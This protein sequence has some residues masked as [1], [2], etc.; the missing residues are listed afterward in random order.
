MNTRIVVA[1]V[2]SVACIA[3]SPLAFGQSQPP[4]AVDMKADAVRLTATGTITAI[5]PATRMVTVKGQ[6]DRTVVFTAGPSVRNFDNMK[7]GDKVAVDYE[8][9]VA[10]ALRKGATGRE[11]LETEAAVRAPAGGMPGGAVAKITTI[12][13]RI[14]N[15]DR[16]RSTATLQGP[17]G[18][19]VVVKVR[20]PQVMKDI[21]PGEEVAIAFYEAVGI[22]VRPAK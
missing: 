3:A 13:A 4:K 14:E 8:T 9:A 20:D 5:D 2:V 7:V 22:A 17:E 11:K 10:I 16:K 6:N 12:V 15:V 1:A 18:R 19:Y 21:K